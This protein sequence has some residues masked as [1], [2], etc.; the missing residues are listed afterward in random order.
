VTLFESGRVHMVGDDHEAE[1]GHHRAPVAEPHRIALLAT[2]APPP[3]W[4][5]E[6]QPPD[7]FTAK[8]LLEALCSQL[9]VEVTVEPVE[10]PFLHPGRSAAIFLFGEAA[11]WV[12]EVHPLVARSWDLEGAA[13]FELDLDALVEAA[14]AERED[15]V[16]VTTFPPV[17]EDFAVVVPEDVPAQRVRETVLKSGGDL[18]GSAEVF[19]LYRGEQVGEGAKSLALRLSFRA[20]D[21]T[22]TDDDVAERRGAITK[23]IEGIGGSL[24][25]AP[26]R[27]AEEAP[28]DA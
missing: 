6:P 9:G 28:P 21:R 12:G 25:G 20:P 7:F 4:R 19:D 14:T 5:G 8:G 13:G 27:E 18:L 24:R 11:G 26:G 2:G 17:H 23:A 16:D 1:S 3:S 10:E 15:Y 22:L